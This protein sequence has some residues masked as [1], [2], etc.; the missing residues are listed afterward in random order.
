MHPGGPLAA[1]ATTEPL[2]ERSALEPITAH[3]TGA[4]DQARHLTSHEVHAPGSTST[5][6]PCRFEQPG[7]D[8][9]ADRSGAQAEPLDNLR[10]CD[11]DV[12]ITCFHTG[13]LYEVER[14][15]KPFLLSN[16]A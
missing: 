5:L 8:P 10:H 4:I 14:T 12:I 13:T 15:V 6:A 2:L 11:Q 3:R 9:S 16:V 1:E 7:G